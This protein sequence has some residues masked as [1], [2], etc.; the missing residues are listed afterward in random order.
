VQRLPLGQGYRSLPLTENRVFGI[1]TVPRLPG[2]RSKNQRWIWPFCQ[3]IEGSAQ[4][5]WAIVLI[6][7][8]SS[9][10]RHTI[11]KSWLAA[12]V[13]IAISSLYIFCC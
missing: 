2:G 10:C 9:G 4:F 3:G 12:G 11:G 1:L 8:F 6:A 7:A 5:K 13:D